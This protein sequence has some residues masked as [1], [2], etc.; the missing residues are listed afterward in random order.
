[1]PRSRQS[2]YY[3]IVVG[4]GASAGGLE[5]LRGFLGALTEGVGAAFVVVQHLSPDH[6]SLLREIL[7]K[8]CV[9]PVVLAADGMDME[10]DNVYLIPPGKSLTCDGMALKLRDPPPRERAEP[11]RT[12]DRLFESMAETLGARAVAV[13]L[14]GTGTDGTLGA[15][16]VVARGGTVLVQSP[17]TAAFDGMPVSAID[18]GVADRV[19]APRDLGRYLAQ[20]LQNPEPTMGPSQA[21]LDEGDARVHDIFRL[22]EA[23]F[24]I[25]FES[26][27][28]ATVLRRIVRRMGLA[29]CADLSEYLERLREP[30]ELQ[31]LFDDLLIDVTAFFRDTDA[32][33]SLRRRVI[34]GWVREAPSRERRIWVCAC[35]GG[36]EAYSLAIMAAEA[37]GVPAGTP[38]PLRIFATDI[39]RRSLERAAAGVFPVEALESMAVERRTRFFDRVEGFYRL[40]PEIRRT[41]VFVAH[42][43]TRQTPFNRMDLVTCR[44]MLIYMRPELQRRVVSVFHYALWPSGALFLGS[45]E[46]V[47][48]LSDRFTELD[49]PARLF[50][51][52]GRARPS[53][54]EQLPHAPIGPPEPRRSTFPVRRDRRPEGEPWLSSALAARLAVTNEAGLIVSRANDLL[55]VVGQP[56]SF[57]RPPTGVVS[58]DVTRMVPPALALALRTALY[59]ARSE[60][61][62]VDMHGVR[63]TDEGEERNLDI[64]VVPLS[65][66]AAEGVQA[67]L[68]T[69]A[70]ST[71]ASE[72]R[73]GVRVDLDELAR[74]RIQV[75][76]ADLRHSREHLQ[77]VVEE[78]EATNEEQQAANEELLATNEELQSAN[79]EMNSLNEELHTV[80]AEYKSKI[81]ELLDLNADMSSLL[82]GL[83]VGVVFLDEKGRVLRFNQVATQVFRLTL[84]DL[85][86]PLD[87]LSDSLV[88]RTQ[89]EALA[90][91]LARAERSVHALQTETGI[92]RA[93]VIPVSSVEGDAR[94][95]L[96][97]VDV[98]ELEQARREVARQDALLR[99]VAVRLPDVLWV[100]GSDGTY[101]YISEAY[102]EMWGIPVAEIKANQHPLVELL[103]PEDRVRVL[104]ELQEGLHGNGFDMTYRIVRPDGT[105]RWARGRGF[106]WFDD[107]GARLGS[108]GVIQDVT[109]QRALEQ[110]AQEATAR[111][112]GLMAALGKVVFEAD[113]STGAMVWHGP[114]DSL[115][116][117]SVDDLGSTLDAFSARIHTDDLGN[118]LTRAQAAVHRGSRATSFRLRT[119]TG[120]Y[121][122]VVAHT[123]FTEDAA[124]RPRAVGALESLGAPQDDSVHA[125]YLALRAT[126]APLGVMLWGFDVG[127][128]QWC[129]DPSILDAVGGPDPQGHLIAVVEDALGARQGASSP[130]LITV[131][132]HTPDGAEVLLAAF[133]KGEPGAL[134]S[135]IAGLAVVRPHLAQ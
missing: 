131:P 66:T 90:R 110:E 117:V 8:S 24:A 52:V 54:Q 37:Y 28:P 21:E 40:K 126:W 108:I 87:H 65:A 95:L 92:W 15:A 49:G 98:S 134:E 128:D 91:S 100:I 96:T 85:G 25:N 1:M 61:K 111:L 73:D 109:A 68:V 89:R 124:G 18:A 26:Y 16:S 114:V 82:D 133:F 34:D 39:S 60:G 70:D 62:P 129:F 56:P 33:E 64:H 93:A 130:V 27:K 45:A 58:F 69:F 83:D 32:W 13:I 104:A 9:L 14:S 63:F 116:G 77:A 88:S 57:L 81:Q 71:L 102:E 84:V 2:A 76:E 3:P 47:L 36:E 44:N 135:Q 112:H 67:E 42:D 30:E 123:S 94:S 86:R 4:V 125:G 31:R 51:V 118:V 55:H 106:P 17:E 121:V 80:N 41:V 29:D 101:Q 119:A 99:E 127:E 6:P 38:P 11:N 46:G 35:S 78:L 72:Y 59:Q 79:E 113:F 5:A 105:L 19:G 22:L 74:N 120:T 107:T 115:L 50:R 7:E 132:P 75:L 43:V 10:V 103:H 20:E 53:Y 122:R 12:I 97:L 23:Q 48:N